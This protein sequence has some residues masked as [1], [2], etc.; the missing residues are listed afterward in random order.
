MEE[1]FLPVG[2]VVLLENA[3]K[4]LMITGFCS[5]SK[6]NKDVIYDYCGCIYPEGI[7]DSSVNMLFNHSQISEIVHMGYK[8][9]LDV[10]FKKKLNQAIKEKNIN[11]G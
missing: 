1:K 4:H 2:T 6:E 5:S 8:S 7:I 3:K 9:D 10:E 11:V